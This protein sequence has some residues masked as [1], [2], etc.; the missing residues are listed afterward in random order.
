MYTHLNEMDMIVNVVKK[1]VC[2]FCKLLNVS[3]NDVVIVFLRRLFC[4]SS[5]TRSESV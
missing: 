4:K 5:S 1:R 3:E 2:G